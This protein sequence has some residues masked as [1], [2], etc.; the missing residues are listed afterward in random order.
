MPDK[1]LTKSSALIVPDVHQDYPFLS[2][3]LKAFPI[4]DFAQVV[5]LGDYFDNRDID[6]RGPK[7]AARTARLIL[8]LKRKLGTRCTLLWGNHDVP[9][10]AEH[11]FRTLGILKSI[12]AQRA[13]RDLC[14][15][16]ESGQ[17]AAAVREVWV[18]RFWNEL[19]PFV[20][21]GDY[22]LSHAGIH[23]K[24]L[25]DPGTDLQVIQR[26]WDRAMADLI[27]N[28]VVRDILK[29]GESRGG[30]DG[31]VGGLTWLDWNREFV[32]DAKFG[33][34]VG[35][36]ASARVR[37]NGRSHCIDYDRSAV[38]ILSD[39]LEVVGI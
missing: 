24:F 9:Y 32:D 31:S 1:M 23:R 18:L 15:R 13:L 36:S 2:R 25:P 8:D 3:I 27:T 22:V 11:A 39:T 21:I 29:P 34:I 4:E 28:G 5:F 12:P 16:P 35:H 7:S 38:G 37:H 17:N 26:E 33:Q 30:E 14:L 10:Y 6:D 20:Q 19:K